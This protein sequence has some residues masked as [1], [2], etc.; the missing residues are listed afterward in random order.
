M[1]RLIE[2]DLNPAS[3]PVLIFAFIAI[4]IFLIIVFVISLI[5]IPCLL[6]VLVNIIYLVWSYTIGPVYYL[7]D[8]KI[9]YY[10]NKNVLL[11]QKI[12]E[13][14]TKPILEGMTIVKIE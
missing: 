13:I 10:N 3:I 7:M 1:S 12:L 9:K 4:S 2:R 11:E 14:T 8:A 6:A 5:L